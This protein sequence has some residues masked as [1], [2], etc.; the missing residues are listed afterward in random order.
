MCVSK[1]RRIGRVLCTVV[2][3]RR[4]DDERMPEL[5]RFGADGGGEC[6]CGVVRA[7]A[8]RRQEGE[9]SAHD[10]DPQVLVEHFA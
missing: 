9:D 1:E 8:H 2:E 7:D 4:T 10:Y 6:I 3:E 5:E